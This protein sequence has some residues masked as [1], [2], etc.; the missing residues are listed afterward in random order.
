V[1]INGNTRAMTGVVLLIGSTNAG[2]G[3]L[4]YYTAYPQSRIGETVRQLGA[5]YVVHFPLDRLELHGTDRATAVEPYLL[6]NG[7]MPPECKNGIRVIH[8]A[9]AAFDGYARFICK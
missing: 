6:A 3:V 7:I 8:T 1:A 2:C 9:R 5:E 4:D